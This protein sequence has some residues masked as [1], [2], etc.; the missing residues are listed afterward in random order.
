MR[1]FKDFVL[2]A[3][4]TR[5]E[6]KQERLWGGKERLSGIFFEQEK[7]GLGYHIV[8][9]CLIYKGTGRVVGT[10]TLTKG[11]WK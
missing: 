10:A 8:V 6:E 7:C 4:K 1:I 9:W 3:P 11:I 2:R 5:E